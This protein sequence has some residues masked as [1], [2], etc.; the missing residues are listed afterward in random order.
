[1]RSSTVASST[2]MKG[3][4]SATPAAKTRTIVATIQNREIRRQLWCLDP[5]NTCF[6]DIV[7]SLRMEGA[8]V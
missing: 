3:L 6:V 7:V 4:A 8:A 1:M 2:G 5:S